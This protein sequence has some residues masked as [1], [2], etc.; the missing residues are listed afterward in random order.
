MA[1][2]LAAGEGKRLKNRSIRKP[3]VSVGG[4]P[5]ICNIIDNLIEAR[6]DTI[7]IVKRKD[8][9]L[10]SILKRYNDQKVKI[11]F[12]DDDKGSGSL[13][14]LSLVNKI[15]TE[16]IVCA[17]CDVICKK[18][19]FVQMIDEGRTLIGQGKVQGVITKVL[20]P[21][22]F[23]RNM[24]LIENERAIHFVKTGIDNGKRG[25]YVYIFNRVIFRECNQLLHIGC[26]SMAIFLDAIMQKYDIGVMQINDMWDV[27]TWEDVNFTN[28]IMMV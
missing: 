19:E 2:I 5:L 24:L 23:D 7:Y 6:I 1:V 27:D 21:S 18:N 12:I 15:N 4:K 26:S 22:V 28:R 14:T 25:G 10:D 20:N 13:Y 3:L 8:D 11:K 17:D 16:W 9:C